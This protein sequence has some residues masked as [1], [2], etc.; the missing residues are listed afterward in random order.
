LE[1][2]FRKPAQFFHRNEGRRLMVRDRI[3]PLARM[4]AEPALR[5]PAHICAT[6]AA[7]RAPHPFRRQFLTRA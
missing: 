6:V 2:L 3:A 4:L 7:P 1:L 5:P